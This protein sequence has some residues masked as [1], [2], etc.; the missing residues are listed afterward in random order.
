MFTRGRLIFVVFFIIAFLVGMI[1]AYRKD[2]KEIRQQYSG[3]YLV[4]FVLVLF[5]LILY[6]LVKFGG[7]F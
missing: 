3:I 6:L 4:F 1:Y 7:R 5:L 2:L